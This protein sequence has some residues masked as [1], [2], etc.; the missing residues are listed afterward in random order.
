[1]L[2]FV[3]DKDFFEDIMK[4]V[5]IFF[6]NVVLGEIFMQLFYNDRQKKGDFIVL[7]VLRLE[8]ILFKVIIFGYIEIVVRDCMFISKFWIGLFS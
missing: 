7:Y 8:D 5:D 1:M 2:V 4:K 3:G 6:G